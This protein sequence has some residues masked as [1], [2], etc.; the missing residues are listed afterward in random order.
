MWASI[1]ELLVGLFGLFIKDVEAKEQLKR[2]LL[3][4]QRELDASSQDS[5][6]LRDSYARLKQRARDDANRNTPTE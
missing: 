6:N 1:V 5:A 4:R 2:N 3:R